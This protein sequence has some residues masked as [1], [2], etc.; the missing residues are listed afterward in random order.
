MGKTAVFVLSTLHLI[1]KDAKGVVALVITH[2]RELAY[3]IL[4]EF[5]RFTKVSSPPWYSGAA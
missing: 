2:T 4:E 1:E 3:Q 5:N